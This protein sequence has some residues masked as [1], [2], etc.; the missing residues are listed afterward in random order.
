[1]TETDQRDSSPL[2]GDELRLCEDYQN[3]ISTYILRT[4]I[5]N[6]D[7]H[8][9]YY[10]VGDGSIVP[11]ICIGEAL[12][13]A[14]SFFRLATLLSQ[15]GYRVILV[16]YHSYFKIENFIKGMESF[17]AHLKLKAAH[18]YGCGLGGFLLQCFG[19]RYPLRVLSLT[20][21]NS[22][23]DTY[24]FKSSIP[25]SSFLW[26]TPSFMLKSPLLAMLPAQSIRLDI[27]AAVDFLCSEL[28]TQNRD[29]YLSRVSLL[30]E[31]RVVNHWCDDPAKLMIL[32]SVNLNHIPQKLLEELRLRYDT[33]HVTYIEL[34]FPELTQPE[35]LAMYI[36]VHLRSV[37]LDPS[38]EAR[39]R[40]WELD[41]ETADNKEENVEVSIEEDTAV[42]FD[43]A[44]NCCDNFNDEVDTCETSNP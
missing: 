22:F 5:L 33:H 23:A 6:R 11:L 36:I 24:H 30:T 1:M 19:E 35:E 25:L 31:E 28:E 41:S 34:P 14:V 40:I 13:T 15:K 32:E 17:L 20:L 38:L 9:Q 3:F 8:W 44:T 16:K 42:S 26:A 4:I 2:N 39:K 18:F 43:D 21:L 37:G 12:T 29:F 27:T 10:D 7:E